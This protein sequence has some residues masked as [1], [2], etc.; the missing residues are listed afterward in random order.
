MK[1]VHLSS[2]R[3]GETLGRLSDYLFPWNLLVSCSRCN[4]TYV[5][6][7]LGTKSL[8]LGSKEEM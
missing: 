4:T 6:T 1:I 7:I 2:I 8:R 5:K 3:D